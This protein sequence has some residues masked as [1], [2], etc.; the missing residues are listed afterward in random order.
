MKV[1][2]DGILLGAWTDFNHDSYILD[3]GTGTGLIALMAAQKQASSQVFGL[4]IQEQAANLARSNFENAPW[5]DRLQA[6]CMDILQYTP[7]HLFDHIVSNPPFFNDG[8]ISDSRHRKTARHTISLPHSALIE[9]SYSLLSQ[10]GK[11]SVILP[12]DIGE[13]F[14]AMGRDND[15]QLIRKT[16][17][18]PR[19]G[20]QAERLLLTLKKGAQ[21]SITPSISTIAIMNAMDNSRTDEFKRLTDSFYL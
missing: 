16:T 18:L 6:K 20:G 15:F 17:V 8:V 1:G 10:Q 7:E 9:K 2:T 3:V 12:I 21:P 11:L 5:K 4:D 14:I 13:A 19:T